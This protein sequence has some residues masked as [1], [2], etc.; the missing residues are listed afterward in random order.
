MMDVFQQPNVGV[1]FVLFPSDHDQYDD[2]TKIWY[3]DR[4]NLYVFDSWSN[5]GALHARKV[6]LDARS[7]FSWDA[8]GHPLV[9][10]MELEV[11]S[12]ATQGLDTV[13][14]S[15]WIP[16]GYRA[17][18]FSEIDPT[19]TTREPARTAVYDRGHQLYR[20]FYGT[21]EGRWAHNSFHLRKGTHV[22]VTPIDAD[23][24]GLPFVRG[25]VDGVYEDNC[26]LVANP[27]QADRDHDGVG[28]ACD[29]CPDVAGMAQADGCPS[30]DMPDGGAPLDAA[31][32]DAARDADGVGDVDTPRDAFMSSDLGATI[33][34]PDGGRDAAVADV[35]SSH[36]DAAPPGPRPRSE[37]DSGCGCSEVGR[38]RGGGSPALVLFGLGALAGAL[39]RARRRAS[40]GP[41]VS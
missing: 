40:T 9:H 19:A 21:E 26:P 28:D 25:V 10:E 35:S 33:P 4:S 3:I 12:P 27:D 1:H 23:Q 36:G 38:L 32:S 7:F 8:S 41:L 20:C 2:T 22:L 37:A 11:D 31:N 39:L 6:A 5:G 13:Y 24:D 30:V 29:K 14:A 34:P 18:F 16:P 17:C 15:A